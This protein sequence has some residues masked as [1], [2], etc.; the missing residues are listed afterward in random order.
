MILS[1]LQYIALAH[2]FFDGLLDL[3]VVGIV[4]NAVGNPHGMHLPWHCFLQKCLWVM[5]KV[6]P[7]ATVPISNRLHNLA[8]LHTKPPRQQRSHMQIQRPYFSVGIHPIL[9]DSLFAYSGHLADLSV[10]N[11]SA[12][13]FALGFYEFRQST[14]VGYSSH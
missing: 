11:A 6:L 8:P 1:G 7:T 9:A 10:S 3:L 13:G 5:T 2:P 4:E 12:L 14:S